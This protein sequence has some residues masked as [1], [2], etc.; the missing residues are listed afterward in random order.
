MAVGGSLWFSLE[1]AP[2]TA[3]PFCLLALSLVVTPVAR[4]AGECG[5]VSGKKEKMLLSTK[6]VS[7]KGASKLAKTDEVPTCLE[8]PFWFSM[9][10][11]SQVHGHMVRITGSEEGSREINSRTWTESGRKGALLGSVMRENLS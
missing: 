5:H 7:A 3:I 8:C 6:P 2:D 4:K 1:G 11:N 10:G 9:T